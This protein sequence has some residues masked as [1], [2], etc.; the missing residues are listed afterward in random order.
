MLNHKYDWA[1]IDDFLALGRAIREAPRWFGLAA[2][3]VVDA[4][5]VLGGTTPC[6]VP[7]A[8]LVKELGLF[9]GACDAD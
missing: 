3:A 4:S 1:D 5:Y 2:E 6:L 8:E 7:L 9:L